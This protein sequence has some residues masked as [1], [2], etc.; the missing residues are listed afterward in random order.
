MTTV[1]LDTTPNALA[2]EAGVGAAAGTLA[3][4]AMSA[5]MAASGRRGHA[6]EYAPERIAHHGLRAGGVGPIRAERLDGVVGGVLHV[7]FGAV[8]GVLFAIGARPVVARI[9]HRLGR[10][11]PVPIEAVA[12]VAFASGIWLVSYWGWVPALG[13][14]PPPDRDRPD[15]QLTML[16]S[17]WVF[18]ATLGIAIGLADRA[19]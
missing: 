18:G 15:R 10:P 19:D 17:H 4:L 11:S 16:V 6:G 2:R 5:A 3:T 13:I 9:R 1:D 7:A 12:G 14:L 8:L